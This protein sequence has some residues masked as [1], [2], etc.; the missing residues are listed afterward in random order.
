MKRTQFV[1]SIKHGLFADRDN[2]KEAM[3][4]AYDL[5]NRTDNPAAVVTAI[6]VVLNTVAKQVLVLED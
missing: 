3:E 1:S 6:H 4:Y 2:M 5:A